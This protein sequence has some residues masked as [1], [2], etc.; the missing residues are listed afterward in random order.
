MRLPLAMQRLRQENLDHWFIG[1]VLVLCLLGTVAV[2]GAGSFTSDASS[3]HHFLRQHLQRLAIGAVAALFFA[4]FDH[5]RLQRGWLVWTALVGGVLLTALPLVL[6]KSGIVR[7][8]AIPG[9]GQFQPL[10]VAKL[11]LVLFLAY[12]LAAPRLDQP[13]GVRQ[14]A[15][16]LG[17]GPAALMLVLA[18]QPNFGNIV[19]MGLVTL[20]M[21]M[22]A[23]LAWRW[24]L[25][26][27]PAGAVALTVGYLEISKLHTRIEQWR[28]G[29]LGRGLDGEP[30]FGY[31]VHQSLLGMGAGGWHGL[32]PGNSHN[33]FAFLPENHTD[34]AFSFLGEELGLIGT[35]LIVAALL[36]MVWRTVAIAERA[37]S[38]FGRLLA[39]G[40]GGMLFIYGTVNV[41]MVTGVIPVMGVPLPFVSYGG[42]ALMTNLAA[43]GV[44]L[45]IDRQGR[46]RQPMPSG[47][48]AAI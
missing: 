29:W 12:R 34:F 14:L 16:T 3:Q 7:W 28:Q 31:Q 25:A 35:L 20:L 19:V 1:A 13:L 40:L 27:V 5:V 22:A 39:L 37:P 15:L 23:G 36:V 33:K 8:V 10:E 11:A 43:V 24:L 42:S 2:Y 6:G 48:R 44:I 18:L 30:P 47:R 26:T 21:L 45:N 38:R 32:S 4:C 9:L 46:R 41:A 17:C